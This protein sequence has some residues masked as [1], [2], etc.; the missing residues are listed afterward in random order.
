[1]ISSLN[2]SI[3]KKKNFKQEHSRGHEKLFGGHISHEGRRI[4][5]SVYS[6]RGSEREATGS[7]TTTTDNRP[8][9]KSY[10]RNRESAEGREDV[11]NLGRGRRP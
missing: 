4:N 3:S 5:A 1:M 2:F 7:K 10:S 9:P 6:S 11:T 8:K